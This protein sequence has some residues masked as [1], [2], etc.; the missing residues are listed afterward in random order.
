MDIADFL[1][2]LESHPSTRSLG[3]TLN[4]IVVAT[5]SRFRPPGAGPQEG[6]LTP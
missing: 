5:C 2:Y 4:E 6:L 1:S 3:S